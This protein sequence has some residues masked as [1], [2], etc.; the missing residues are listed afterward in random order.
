MKYYLYKIE[1]LVNGKIYIGIT[2]NPERRFKEHKS[3]YGCSPLVRAAI[4][5]YGVSSF[6]FDLLCCGDKEYIQELEAKAISEYNS[7]TLGHGYNIKT[8]EQIVSNLPPESKKKISE[9]LKEYYLNN[10]HPQQGKFRDSRSTNVPVYI[11][12]F[13][14][15]NKE[16]AKNS[17]KIGNVDYFRWL[18][19]EIGG[20]PHSVRS[21]QVM[22]K[23]CYVGGFWFPDRLTAAEVFGIT[24]Y[25]INFRIK[26]N[27]TEQHTSKTKGNSKPIYIKD[28]W[29]PS[30]KVAAKALNTTSSALSQKIK[31]KSASLN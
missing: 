15:P 11:G 30:R 27:A 16:I 6:S 12:G 9:S 28:F 2:N 31:R 19:V 25:A 4:L 20:K 17:L 21:N 22:F 26:I 23:P 1:N 3:S 13:W 5:K 24:L 29:F 10:P 7:S 8:G 14:F 18:M